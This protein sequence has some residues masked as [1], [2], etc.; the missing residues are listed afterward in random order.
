[1]NKL[2]EA[3]YAQVIPPD[4]VDQAE[5]SWYIPHHMT[6]HNGK[7]RVVFNCSFQHGGKNLNQLLLPGP[8]LGP[9]LMSVFL[10]DLNRGFDVRQWASNLPQVLDNIPTEAKSSSLVMWLTQE[11]PDAQESAL[12]LLWHCTSNTL[13]YKYHPIESSAPTMRHIYR[14]LASQYDPLGYI[15]PYTTKAKVLVQHLWDKKR[16]WDDP[17][18]PDELLHAWRTWEQE[19]PD[20]QRISIPRVSPK[21]QQSIPC[22]ELCAALTGA[23]LAKFMKSELSVPIRQVTLWS[24]STIV[25]AWIQADSCRFKVFDRM[26]VAEIQELIDPK[27]WCYVDSKS[28]PADDIM[29]GKTLAELAKPSRWSQGPSFL[30]LPPD[31]WPQSPFLSLPTED[32]ELKQATFCGLTVPVT[33]LAL[34]DC[35]P[36]GS[37]KELLAATARILHGAATPMEVLTAEDYREAELSLLHQAQSQSFP[38]EMAHFKSS[39]SLPMSSCLLCLAPEYDST[40]HLIRVGGCLRRTEQLDEST[41]HPIVLDPKHPLSRFIIQD[42]DESLHHPGAER[43]FAEVRHKYWILRGREA[44][45]QHQRTCL[46]CK[47]WRGQPSIPRMA[48]LPPSRLRLL[49]PAFYSTGVDCFGPYLIKIG[50]R[51][52]KRWGIIFKCLTTRAVYLDLLH[53][54]DTD[55]FLMA[56]RRFISRRGKPFEIIS[57]QGTNFRG[58]ERALQKDFAVLHPSLQEQLASHQISFK[59]NPPGASHF[60]S[61]WEREIRSL[62][63]ALCSILGD[64]IVTEEVLCTVLVEM[65]GILNS[66][67]LRYTS[68][69]VAGPDSVTPNMLLMGRP[70][71]SLPQV[72]Y[73]E[74]EMLS[75]RRWRHSQLLADQFWRRFLRNYLPE[76]Q[77]RQKWHKEAAC[78]TGTVVMIVDH[79]LPRALWPVGRV[80]KVFPGEDGRA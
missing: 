2:K 19:L 62:K 32:A 13:S 46:G 65:E 61:C 47:Q 42:F 58:G 41:I 26:R 31:Q 37:Y 10:R 51:H 48:D 74:S 45:R 35:N 3:G 17:Q 7:N 56:L 30:L 66:K 76:L 6:Q 79:Q 50:R 16:E 14:V 70:D 9:S 53:Q 1:M 23:Q 28:N 27:D 36:F 67:P 24:D 15:V 75:K 38:V 68:S 69:D 33:N 11:Q 29:R 63:S 21:K 73:P 4:Q 39:K 77:V 78:Q 71:S 25:L 72:I 59:F 55:S 64:Q 40:T 43:V 34:S 57:D 8:T 20:I 22:L 54:M 44:I 12:G 18:L 60:G 80:T 5:E 49:Q 52:E